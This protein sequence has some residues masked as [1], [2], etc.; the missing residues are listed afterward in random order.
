MKPV[1]TVLAAALALA[2]APALA[3]PYT[4]TIFIGD[5]LSDSGYFR[6][7]LIRAVGPSGALIGRFTTN[8]GLVWSEYV[9]EY[10]GGNATSVNQGGTNYA[11]GGA[12]TG[13]DT[14][15]QLGPTPSLATQTRNYLA[16][17][18]GR[19]DANALYTVW[20]GGNDLFAVAAGAPAQ[21]TIAN[22]VAA[23]IG[24]VN[25]LTQAGARYILVPTVPDLGQTPQYRAGGAA[26]QAAGT[27]TSTAF[28]NGLYN[29]LASAG[30]RVIPLDTFNLLR[31]IT[32][33]PAP[34]GFTN[35]TG[36]ACQ[37]Q[38]TAQ[39]ITCNPNTYVS[40]DAPNT[41]AFAD[42]VHPS[43]AAHRIL[44]DYALSVLEAPRLIALLPNSASM[45]GRSR[46]EAVASHLGGKPDAD[47]MRWWADTRGDF[48]RYGD[49]DVYD[50]AGPSVTGGVDWTRGDWVFGVFAGYGRQKLDWGL[51]GGSFDQDDTTLGGFAAWYG[52][53]VW[54]NAQLSYSQVDFDTDRNVNLGPATRVHH[55]SADGK[56]I[57][58]GLNA[59]W[60]FG[61]GRLQH[62]PV[63]GVLAQNIEIDGFAESDPQL[64]TSLAYPKQKFDSLIGSIGWQLNFRYSD[65]FQPYARLTVDREFE[66]APSEARARL[67]T[68]TALGEFAVP[69][70]DFD[71]SYGTALFG[72]R[73]KLFG[74][75]AN[76]GA[77][78]TLGLQGGHNTTVFATVGRGF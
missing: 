52:E 39:S 67:Q 44:A 74:L 17:T 49:G 10:Y 30:L 76:L 56:N 43:A 7:T 48:Q 61:E 12:R 31:E 63:I 46:A 62:G 66:D 51:R 41:Y 47:G 57:T 26:A 1:R 9:A 5:S 75:D 34:Y 14:V 25:T 18:G 23:E 3:Q 15:G 19:A 54:V 8:P 6:P 29:G 55:G 69:N 40:P 53:R 65:A 16:S 20:G 64:A 58:A 22:A 59:G 38:I 35:V 11:V 21:S 70:R 13:I 32:S 68:V 4:Q 71:Q 78:V 42:G 33:N 60:N 24:V 77:S 73:T 27:Q 72:A 37:P 50:G 36:T 2:T 28:N 45:V